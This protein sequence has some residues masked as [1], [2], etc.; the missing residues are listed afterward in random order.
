[1]SIYIPRERDRYFEDH[2]RGYDLS[3]TKL[4]DEVVQLK[5]DWSGLLDEDSDTISSVAYTDSGVTTSNKSNT[6]SVTDCDVTG[7]GYTKI[8]VTTAAS[9]VYEKTIGFHDREG[10]RTRDY[11]NW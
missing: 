11:G 4:E 6:T 9:R 2:A 7:I 3:T 10:Q 5:I 8:A 1:M